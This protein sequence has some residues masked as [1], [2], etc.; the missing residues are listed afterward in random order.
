MQAGM[1]DAVFAPMYEVLKR[2]GVQFRF[3]HRVKNLRLAR[4][5]RSI[6]SIEMAR[7]VDLVDPDA[8]YAPLKDVHGLP[9]W[10]AEPLHEQIRDPDRWRG[11]DLE[12]FF[13][14]TKDADPDVVLHTGADFDRIVFG[15]PLG[16]VPYI[17]AE[18][19]AHN[20]R[21]KAMV[22]TIR[23]V[24]TES[25]QVWVSAT[26]RQLGWRM[27]SGDLAGYV[28]PFNTFADMPQLIQRESWPRRELPGDCAYLC[29]VMPTPTQPPVPGDRAFAEHQTELVRQDA[30]TYLRRYIGHL[31]PGAM[32]DG[33]F[34][35]ELLVGAGSTKG[36]ERFDSQFWRANIDPSERY[37]Q[38]V[39]GSTRYRLKTDATGYDNLYL[40][41]DWIDN[42]FN[43]GCI[44]A[45]VMSGLLAAHAISGIPA[46]SEIV[47]YTQA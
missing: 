10:P 19:I 25:F 46:L 16:S 47:G 31:W 37:V 9:C 22:D 30:I 26:A 2:R 5:R 40:A 1:G 23:T 18:L 35:W 14:S 20:P 6:A 42:G 7:Q 41:G 33:E 36:V 3:F 15:I 29:G 34:R 13:A 44:E 11:Q 38:S 8:E 43:A 4:D 27:P 39:P 45:A 17:C 12:S 32:K 21:W 24:Q 28:D